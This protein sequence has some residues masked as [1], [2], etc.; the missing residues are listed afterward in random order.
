MT[1]IRNTK[2][3]KAGDGTVTVNGW[4]QDI[5][6]LGGISFL[7]LRDRFGTVQVTMPKKKIE[8][9]LFEMLTTLS[10]ESAVSVTGEVK[11][12][13]QTALGFEIIP[14]SA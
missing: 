9:G 4:A 13:N 7:T 6:N 8:P 2:T 12:S 14:T 3:I 10:R 1:L 5:R 11:E